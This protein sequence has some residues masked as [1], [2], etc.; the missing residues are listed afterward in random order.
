M[1]TL[2]VISVDG[3]GAARCSACNGRLDYSWIVGYSDGT[4][5]HFCSLHLPAK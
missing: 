1:T 3:S 5:R 2:T 4:H